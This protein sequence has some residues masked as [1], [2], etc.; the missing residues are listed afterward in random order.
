MKKHAQGFTTA[1]RIR[2]RVLVVE[3]PKLYPWATA[4]YSMSTS[5][6]TLLV[7]EYEYE[8]IAKTWVQVYFHEYDY[9][10]EYT[11][12]KYYIIVLL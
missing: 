1:A 5:T 7:D 4:L 9:E 12:K 10:Y 11:L 3:I 8:L 2:T 6:L